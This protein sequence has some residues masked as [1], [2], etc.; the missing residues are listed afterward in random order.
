[1]N[2]NTQNYE[3]YF[4][5]YVDNALSDAERVAVEKFIQ[6]N[7]AYKNT[8]DLLVQTVLPKE[9]IVFE[10]KALLYRHAELEAGLPSPFKKSLYRTEAKIVNKYFTR[11]RIVGISS[12]AALFLLLWG[13]TFYLNQPIDRD[14]R[15]TLTLN[16]TSPESLDPKILSSSIVSNVLPEKKL[17]AKV[18]AN[19]QNQPTPAVFETNYKEPISEPTVLPA[20]KMAAEIEILSTA[21]TNTNFSAITNPIKSDNSVALNTEIENAKTNTINTLSETT[22][23]YN[24]IDIDET[25]RAL[26]I[27][28]FEIDGEKLRGLTRRFNALLKRNRNEKQK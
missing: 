13:Y 26:Y 2:I 1:M 16:K 11:T 21:T 15:N 23:S 10:D 25:D 14:L 28:N 20:Q 8:F 6:E 18:Q 27:A 7:P 4:L 3:S 12:I 22:E 24:N 5:L 9:F 19:N 17:L